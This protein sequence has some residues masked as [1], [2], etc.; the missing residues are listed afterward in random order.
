MKFLNLFLS[1]LCRK[2]KEEAGNYL[3]KIQSVFKINTDDI[4]LYLK[5]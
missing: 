1:N 5:L 2:H 3:P 4:F